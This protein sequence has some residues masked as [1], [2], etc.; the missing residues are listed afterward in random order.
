MFL[1]IGIVFV[2][3]LGT[4]LYAACR[5]AGHADDMARKMIPTPVM[6]VL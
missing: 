5:L 2:V 1:A 6:W 3:F 4:F